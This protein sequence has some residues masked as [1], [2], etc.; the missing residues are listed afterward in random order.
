MNESATFF[1]HSLYFSQMRVM[2]VSDVINF[3]LHMDARF[4]SS[5][6][7]QLPAS[8]LT[9][10]SGMKY[11]LTQ[12]YISTMQVCVSEQE[13]M[14]TTCLGEC[15]CIHSERGGVRSILSHAHS[16]HM[17]ERGGDRSL[18]CTH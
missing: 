14:H 16:L 18:R 9:Q 13:E 11:P 12:R 5:L 2:T 3:S 7:H 17:S 4:R 8:P 15:G 1:S 6:S 10:G